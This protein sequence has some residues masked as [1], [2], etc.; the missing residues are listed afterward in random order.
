M[1]TSTRWFIRIGIIY[2]ICGILLS[3]LNE[4][5]L[6]ANVSLLPVYWHMIILGWITQLIIGVSIWMF[7]RKHRN[8]KRRESILVWITFWTLNI[9]LILRFISEP[10]IHL[11]AD[12]SWINGIV[13][14]SACLQ[15]TAFIFYSV[16]IWPR[17]QSKKRKPGTSKSKA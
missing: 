1:P 13:I 9:G 16:E 3:F 17:L 5:G 6:A 10:M 15:V 8:R 11:Y 7:P 4:L 2:L 12:S 14:L